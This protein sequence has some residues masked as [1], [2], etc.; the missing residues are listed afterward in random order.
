MATTDLR[1]WIQQLDKAGELK[2]IGEAA[3][4]YLEMAEIADRAAKLGKGTAK[5]GGSACGPGG[6]ALLFENVTGFPGAKV[7]MNQFGSE[8]RMRLALEVDSLDEIAGRIRALIHPETPTTLMDKLKLLPKL[9]EVGSYFP[10][11][12]ASKDAACK[13]VVHRRVEDGGEG[14]DLRKLPVLT[15]WPLDGGPFITLPCVVTRDPKSGKRN[16]GMYRMQVYD[17]ETTG[18]HWQRQKNAAEHLRDRLRAAAESGAN[19]ASA[20]VE[21]MAQTA[22]GTV[23]A[24]NTATIPATTLSKVREGRM[25]VAVAIGTDP[26]T[27]FAAIVPAPPD[28]EE[29]LIAG[30]LRGRPVEL[31][32]CETVDL[33]VPAHAEYILEGYVNLGELRTEGPFGDHTGFY[34]LQDDYPVFHVTCITHR[35]D[36]I[37]AATV[38]GKP[39]M[40]DAWMGKA[41]E[42][43]FLPLMQLT[44][45]EIVDVC[46]PP[47]AVFHNLMIVSIR[48]SYAGHA[49]K[50]MHGIWAM[51]QAMFTKCIVV[52]DEDCDAQDLAEVT[53]RVANNID[54][55]RDIQFT[56]GPVDTLDHASRLPNYGSKMGIDATRKWAAE[57]FTRPWP[58]MLK[59]EPGVVA[60]I[61]SIWKKLG[62]E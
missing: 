37:Y 57:G 2:R 23:A 14:I 25:E 26:A 22:G 44:L 35:K 52:V 50:V 43:I 6:P 9:A 13:Q 40:E 38:V 60:R 8:R 42:R 27:T 28:V 33:E 24:E 36:P 12:I 41:V 15:T 19:D 62:I 30:F 3:S 58:Q 56:L 45:P 17:G 10:K 39:P 53:L 20:R 59:M 7:L 34:T 48:K 1:D 16:V 21:L 54:P 61:D 55:E 11:V 5:A 46:L 31:V 18:M 29:Y 4:P 51:G 32:K 49:R 47:E